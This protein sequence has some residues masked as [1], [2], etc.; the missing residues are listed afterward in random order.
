ML[1]NFSSCINFN[2]TSINYFRIK[3]KS[4]QSIKCSDTQPEIICL[5][6]CP[7]IN[8]LSTKHFSK[9]SFSKNAKSNSFDNLKNS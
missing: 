5:S 4:G 9:F 2:S 3:L 1:V 8:V 6:S 7:H